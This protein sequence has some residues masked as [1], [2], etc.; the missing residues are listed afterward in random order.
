MPAINFVDVCQFNSAA[1]GTADFVA[2]SAA[3][4]YLAPVGAGAVD[5][6][7]YR[8]RAESSD[9][10]QWEVGFGVYAAGTLAR[11]TV[12]KS[13]SANA[14]V[15]FTAPPGVA[16]VYLA[17]DAVSSKNNLSEIQDP[18]AA[19][20]NLGI[21]P[22]VVAVSSGASYSAAAADDLIIVNKSTGSATSVTMVASATRTR[23]PVQIKDGKGDADTNNITVGFNGAEK[24]DGLTTVIISTSFGVVSLAPNPAGGWII[25]SFG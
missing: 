15:N 6:A 7:T 9:L 24:A 5:G 23:G 1:G 3:T 14:K 21:N 8:Y 10:T 13:S 11:T 2:A 25:L 12:L 16:I 20:A 22:N 19:R 17:E 18:A 4:G